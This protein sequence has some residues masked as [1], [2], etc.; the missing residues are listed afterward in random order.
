MYHD[1]H[2]TIIIP[3]LNE[4]PSIGRVLEELFAL[5]VCR[6]CTHL[7]DKN[8]DKIAHAA[9]GTSP[10]LSEQLPN[11]ARTDAA[12]T[13]SCTC[14]EGNTNA[15][16]LVDQIIV[17]DN[18]STDD[19]AAIA[20]ACGAIVVEEP[21]RGYGAACLAALAAPV[22]KDLIVFVDAD[23]SVVATELPSLL[24]PI[25]S[26][27][28]LVIGSR[29]LGRCEKGALS[30]PQALGNKLASALMRLLWRAKVT[31]L[32]PFRAITNDALTAMKMSDKQFGWTV[33]MQIRAYQLPIETVEVPVSTTK[34]IG[35]SKISGTVRGVIGAAHGI[36]GTIFKLYW[37]QISGVHKRIQLHEQRS[38]ASAMHAEPANEHTQKSS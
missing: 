36:L 12:K 35:K 26:G 18:G 25:M 9:A 32:G 2:V 1:R 3:A 16:Q 21:V 5:S 19:T 6:Q 24:D 33:E 31:D 17:C 30:I 29:T 38:L 28:Q 27:A 22:E 4:A 7:I 8:S 34:R 14:E 11:V 20:D 23:H 10:G 15:G 13:Q 37:R